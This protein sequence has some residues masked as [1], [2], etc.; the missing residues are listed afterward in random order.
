MRFALEKDMTTSIKKDLFNIAQAVGFCDQ[1]QKLIYACEVPIYYRMIDLTMATYCKEYNQSKEYQH[2]NK[3]IRSLSSKCFDILV[4]I[5]VKGKASINLLQ[6]ELLIDKEKLKSCLEKLCSIG[7]IQKISS[8]SYKIC[9]WE[10]F[11][12]KSLLAIELKLSKW[13]EALEQGIYNQKF[14]EYSFVVL[15]EERIHMNDKI[16]KLYR[17]KNIGLIYLNNSRN[18]IK[19]KI[20]PKKNKNIDKYMSLFYR[21]KILKDFNINKEKWKGI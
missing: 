2:C 11:I 15:D 9:E 6:R 10:V 12:P 20:I 17:E 19:M 16:E 18:D 8:Y 14:A 7:L 13:Q 3:A 4:L 5:G 21:L 1:K